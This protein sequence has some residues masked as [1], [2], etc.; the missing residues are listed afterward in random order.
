M[1]TPLRLLLGTAGKNRMGTAAPMNRLQQG[2]GVAALSH[3]VA[4]CREG[5]RETGRPVRTERSS[6]P[7]DPHPLPTPPGGG[8]GWGERGGHCKRWTGTAGHWGGP[9]PVLYVP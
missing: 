8:G 1:Y 5:T 2:T 7:P 3:A 9:F 4:S 6:Q